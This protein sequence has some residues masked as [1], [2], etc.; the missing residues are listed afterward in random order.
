MPAPTVLVLNWNMRSEVRVNDCSRTKP[1]SSNEWMSGCSQ[2]E[3][4]KS[5][6]L[7]GAIL[8]AQVTSYV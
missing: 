4:V 8:I 3:A 6:S 2:P 1:P 5:S 7:V